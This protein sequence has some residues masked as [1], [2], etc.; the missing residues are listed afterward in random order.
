M[1]EAV[2]CTPVVDVDDFIESI[3]DGS[4][5]SLTLKEELDDVLMQCYEGDLFA[6]SAAVNDEVEHCSCECKDSLSCEYLEEGIKKWAISKLKSAKAK[7][8]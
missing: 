6:F 3:V 5:C 1:A 8:L 4:G 2:A 7:Q